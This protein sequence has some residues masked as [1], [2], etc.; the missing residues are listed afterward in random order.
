MLS[1]QQLS[2][3]GSTPFDNSAGVALNTTV[4]IKW[5]LPLQIGTVSLDSIGDRFM[6][7][8]EDKITIH[9]VSYAEEQTELRFEVTHQADV[10]YVWSFFALQSA[11]GIYQNTFEMLRYTTRAT[12]SPLFIAGRLVMS[13]STV[14]PDFSNAVVM[15][16]SDLSFL[17]SENDDGPGDALK[18][19]AKANPYTGD[20][21][22]L[23]VQPGS[24]YLMAMMFDVDGARLETIGIGVYSDEDG[25]PQLL[26]ITTENLFN[27]DIEMIS[28]DFEG[29]NPV[30]ATEA[31]AVATSAAMTAD[32]LARPIY[33]EARNHRMP[34]EGDSDEWFAV[35][36]SDADSTVQMIQTDGERVLDHQTM[37]FM[38]IPEDERFDADIAT[39]KSIPNMFLPSRDAIQVA[40]QNGLSELLAPAMTDNDVFVEVVYMLS[41]FYFEYDQFV[42]ATS[43]PFWTIEALI[44]NQFGFT[45]AY[46]LIDAVTGSFIGKEIK[47]ELWGPVPMEL[48]HSSP[49]HMTSSVPLQTTVSFSFNE[50][51]QIET[52]NGDSRMQTWSVLPMDLTIHDITYSEDFRTVYMDVVHAAETDY[53]WTFQSVRSTN[54]GGLQTAAV[55]NYTTQAT[56]SPLVLAGSLIWPDG[57]FFPQPNHAMAVVVLLDSPDYFTNGMNGPPPDVRNAGANL[58]GTWD[59][60]MANVRPGTYYPAVFV[61]TNGFEYGQLLA[62]G[63]SPDANDNPKS[64]T[65]SDQSFTQYNIPLRFV[66]TGPD[67]QRTDVLQV[68]DDV[69]QHV[70]AQ[71]NGAELITLFGREELMRPAMPTGT[72]YEWSFIFFETATDTVQMMHADSDGI[73]MVDRFHLS[74]VPEEERIP[75]ELVRPL[76]TTFIGSSQAMS[77]ALSNGL[78]VL[79]NTTPN[80]AWA[81]VR[82]SLSN[83]YFQHPDILDEDS[84]PF[85]DIQYNAEIW[86]MDQM[87]WQR[88]ANFLI[89]ALTGNFIFKTETT[90]IE[91]DEQVRKV[92]LDQNYPNPFNP[93]TV[94]GFRLSVFGPISLK[95]YDILGREVAVLVDGV[96]PAGNHRVTFDASA[97]PSGIYLYRL[98]A[99]G[100]MIQRKM[101]VVK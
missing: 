13:D 80:E 37:H 97:L 79:I 47:E 73:T 4:V 44:G 92:E 59:Y 88:E 69:R 82:Y 64:V 70:A 86:N 25:E 96:M 46:F 17:D 18:S 22:L 67:H 28:T 51:I 26:E 91:P 29:G 84:P 77:T 31:F 7:F 94:I 65:I 8:P 55:V 16:L 45:S 74:T 1:A 10:D 40:M 85:W 58:M 57:D 100:E 63:Y 27:T 19:A 34:P 9:S 5:N 14:V 32:P 53:V 87:T 20:Y 3:T 2:L 71:E 60:S 54:G 12:P 11:S 36:Y 83:F 39:I 101:T 81:Q 66:S 75:E 89:D 76:P 56:V 93:V 38:D 49:S 41:H 6:V 21:T 95:V 33:L 90:G 72:S 48:M 42:S 78:D 62:Y 30:D 68:L 43:N 52:L 61:F 23:N 99:G 24:Y 15:L 98:E 50:P 35:F